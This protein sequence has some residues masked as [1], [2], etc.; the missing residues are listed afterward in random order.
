MNQKNE[1]I[2]QLETLRFLA[3]FVIFANHCTFM[4]YYRYGGWWISNPIMGV[5][6]FFM[7]FGFGLYYAYSDRTINKNGVLFAF[8]KIKPIYPLYMLSMVC[9]IPYSVIMDMKDTSLKLSIVKAGIKLLGG[10]TLLQSGTGS[11]YTALHL[12]RRVGFC[13]VCL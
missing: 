9:M 13:H 3:M 7:L 10:S 4:S 8:E 6:Y 1:R 2:K 12:M 11:S 5:D